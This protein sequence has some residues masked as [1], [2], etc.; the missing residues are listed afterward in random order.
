MATSNPCSICGNELRNNMYAECK[1]YFCMN[2][3]QSH[4]EKLSNEIDQ[5]VDNQNDL[6][7]KI[8]ESIYS[9]F[10]SQID[11][12]HKFPIEKVKQNHQQIVQLLDFKW[13]K[14]KIFSAELIQQTE[15][16]R[17]FRMHLNMF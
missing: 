10:L 9:S 16:K 17:F 8:E 6:P 1:A 7:D 14:L 3:F 12:W 2:A 5:L 11:G 15:T 13:I 4:R